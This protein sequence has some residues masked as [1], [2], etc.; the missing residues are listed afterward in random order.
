MGWGTLY[1]VARER[2]H[3]AFPV[4]EAGSVGLTS[5]AVRA[6]ARRERFQ[7]PYPG[8]IVAPGYRSDHRT[9]LAA[10]QLYLGA[11]AAASDMSA[12]WLYGLVPHPPA[13]PQLLLPHGRRVAPPRT[14]VHRSRHVGEGDRTTVDGISVLRVPFLLLAMAA[15]V[16]FDAL[17]GIALT[18]RQHG[19]LIVDELGA[20]LAAAG[21]MPGRPL[22]VRVH[23]ELC[24]DGSDSVFEARVRERLRAAGLTPSDAPLPVVVAGGRTLHLDIAFPAARVAIECQGF[25]AHHSRRQ[26]D[27]DARRDNSIALAGDWLVLKLTWDRFVNDWD[28]FLRELQAALAQRGG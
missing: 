8:V 17:W 24:R 1:R 20:R 21:A 11:S 3:G 12:A 4:R 13:R 22:V 7:R 19:H 5:D 15:R 2:H 28:G 18:A 6:R 9:W 16:G 10:V 27:R 26:L 25:V 23:A 14:V